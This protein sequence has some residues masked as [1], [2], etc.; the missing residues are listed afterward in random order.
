LIEI[1]WTVIGLIGMAASYENLRYSLD[2]LKA[3]R[4]MN[5]HNM[6]RHRDMRVIAYGHFRNDAIRFGQTLTITVVGVIAMCLPST[7]Q[8]SPVTPTGLIVTGGLFTLV[9]LTVLASV[10]DRM[11][12]NAIEEMEDV[13]R[14]ADQEEQ[15]D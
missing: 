11:Q 10:L 14:K 2:D 13:R 12:R 9:L 6:A 1:F 4:A 3:L 7:Q 5:G 15:S 8:S